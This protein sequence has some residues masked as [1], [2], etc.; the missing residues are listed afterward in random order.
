[1]RRIM[2]IIGA[3]GVRGEEIYFLRSWWR[4]AKKGMVRPEPK[5]RMK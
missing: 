2:T 4:M 5:K 1:M 3:D